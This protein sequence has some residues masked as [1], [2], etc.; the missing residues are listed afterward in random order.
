MGIVVQSYDGFSLLYA[1]EYHHQS[2]V[3]HHQVQVVLGQVK[4]YSLREKKDNVICMNNVKR[5]L[6]CCIICSSCHTILKNY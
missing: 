1:R 6:L 3:C 5:Q 2:S 4:V